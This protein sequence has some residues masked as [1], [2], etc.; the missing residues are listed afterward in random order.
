MVGKPK[1]RRSDDEVEYHEPAGLTPLAVKAKPSREEVLADDGVQSLLATK[2][3]LLTEACHRFLSSAALLS[4]AE[5]VPAADA[6]F[7][8]LEVIRALVSQDW[9]P[10]VE[11]YSALGA[12]SGVREVISATGKPGSWVTADESKRFVRE[13]ATRLTRTLDRWMQEQSKNSPEVRNYLVSLAKQLNRSLLDSRQE[14]SNELEALVEKF[15]DDR[16]VSLCVLEP[17][18]LYLCP[19]CKAALSEGKFRKVNC[20]CG[21][22]INSPRAVEKVSVC[23]IRSSVL[24]FYTENM[25]LEEG[26]A[27]QFRRLNFEA[28]TGLNVLGSSGVWHEI[29]V[30]AESPKKRAR[31]AC[32]CKSRMLKLE[33][34]YVF[35]GKLRDIAI[36]H[37]VVITTAKDVSRDVQLAARANAIKICHGALDKPAEEWKA[38]LSW[39]A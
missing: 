19:N 32:E 21:Q 20:S 28:R 12:L 13:S 18:V 10:W 4:S 27:Y 36:G 6:W 33:D 14:A 35:A 38:V 5:H 34:V 23:R 16:H 9:L 39:E 7:P 17:V 29:D 37:G 25:W 24:A 11:A 8:P 22:A 3:L 15:G 1:R 30:L 2:E 31:L 26:V